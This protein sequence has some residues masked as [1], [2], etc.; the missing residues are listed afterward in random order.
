MSLSHL[1]RP[2]SVKKLITQTFE[3]ITRDTESKWFFNGGKT[4]AIC[5]IDEFPL[6]RDI[7]KNAPYKKDFYI[8]DVG[9]GNFQFSKEMSR[10]INK[11][12]ANK[13]IRNDI[14]VHIIGLRGELNLEKE[15]YEEGV[16]QVYNFGAFPIENLREALA[17][18]GLKDIKLDFAI[19]QWALRHLVDPVGT[20]VQLHEL[21]STGPNTGYFLFDGFFYNIVG[22]EHSETFGY[23]NNNINRLLHSMD[24]PFLACGYQSTYSLNHFIMK[25]TQEVTQVPLGY[26]EKTYSA[27]FRMQVE[28]GVI[29]RFSLHDASFFNIVF[30]YVE[31][32]HIRGD[33]D[34]YN[35]LKDKATFYEPF[36]C[37]DGEGGYFLPKEEQ[38]CCPKSLYQYDGDLISHKTSLQVCVEY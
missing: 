19:S 13:N 36:D 27:G 33:E 21:L 15:V 5:G 29:Q 23:N 3:E 12:V 7:I 9:A 6:I 16:C 32:R 18:R 37:H 1:N 11:D 10:L 38:M 14:K 35:S 24:E 25:K 26:T 28:S 17:E 8:M 4:Y 30:E 31:E 22:R 20:V 34:L 2:E